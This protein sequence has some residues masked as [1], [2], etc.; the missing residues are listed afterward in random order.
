M[1]W[2]LWLAWIAVIIGATALPWTNY[3]G[4][5]HWDEVR[6]IPFYGQP[7]ALGD[8]FA[9]VVLFIPFGFFLR[10]AMAASSPKRIWI[11][12]VLLAT[13]LSTAVEIFQIYS[14]NRVPSTTDICGN[15][16]GTIIGVLLSVPR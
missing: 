11:L 13:A 14:H 12:T 7:L 9:N 8:V 6:W 2:K 10:R 16:L 3:A 4:H 1:W 5:A 15:L